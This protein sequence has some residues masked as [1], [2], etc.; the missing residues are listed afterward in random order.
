[1][2]TKHNLAWSEGTQPSF[3]GNK[4]LQNQA[5]LDRSAVHTHRQHVEEARQAFVAT[6]GADERWKSLNL[7]MGLRAQAVHEAR[8]MKPLVLS[9]ARN[10]TLLELKSIS[11]MQTANI[12][13]S[14]AQPNTRHIS[15]VSSQVQ[16]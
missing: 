15:H 10:T 9:D 2:P 6:A 8:R 3:T 16:R 1:M 12:S 13:S 4:R 5:S 11:Q 7:Q 14:F